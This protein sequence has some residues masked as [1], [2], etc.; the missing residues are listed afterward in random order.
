MKTRI[1]LPMLI[2]ILLIAATPA[3]SRT[4]RTDYDHHLDFHQYRTYSWAEVE[5]PDSLWDDRVKEAI[6]NVLAAKGWTKVPEGGDVS[7][8]VFGTTRNKRTYET[9]YTGFG[10]WRWGGFGTATTD[11]VVHPVGTLL[12]DMFDTRTKKLIWRGSASDALSNKPEKNIKELQKVVEK[13]FEHFPPQAS[14]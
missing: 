3:F 6:D 10:G 2:A 7:I 4:I 13:M 8:T 1:H 9:F 14:A 12:V 11:V 5:T